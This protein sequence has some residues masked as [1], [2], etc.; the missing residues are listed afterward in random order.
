MW[1]DIAVFS[2]QSNIITI[3][4]CYSCN[5]V[6]AFDFKYRETNKYIFFTININ[7]I[8]KLLITYLLV[9][10]QHKNMRLQIVPAYLNSFSTHINK[11][12]TYNFDF[13]WSTKHNNILY[14]SGVCISS[15]VLST[16]YSASKSFICS[17]YT[18]RC[19]LTDNSLSGL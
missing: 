19:P 5:D 7:F 15:Y 14:F 8:C 2:L 1:Q 9:F 6:V 3:I 16:L 13:H 10:K 12:K 18:V 11:P 4:L 17:L